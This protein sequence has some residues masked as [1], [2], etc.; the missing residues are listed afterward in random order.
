V[1]GRDAAE[2]QTR[3]CASREEEDGVGSEIR[4]ISERK[5]MSV[6]CCVV[7]GGG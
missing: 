7:V 6:L 4:G 1:D 3:N 5:G 2:M